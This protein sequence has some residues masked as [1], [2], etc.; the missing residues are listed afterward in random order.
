[1][2]NS[3]VKTFM[4][5]EY[6]EWVNTLVADGKTSGS[7][8]SENLIAYTQLNAKRMK[9]LNKT[10]NPSQEL[11]TAVSQLP[12]EMDWLIIT[13][14][15]CGDAAQN[16]PFIAK[17]A[18]VCPNVNLHL[19][20]RDENLDVMERYL[21]NG[22]RSIPKFIIKDRRDSKDLAIWGPRPAAAQKLVDA[23][24]A[25]EIDIP[26]EKF[27]EEIHSWY[28][29]DKNASLSYELTLLFEGLKQ[30]KP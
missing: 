7:N 23:N 12:I 10:S 30:T 19:I 2:E 11:I 24:K 13:E 27:A 15:W 4:Y 22:S 28:A 3:E 1:M 18:A 25:R 14:A 17:L 26:F 16:I 5:A 29:H 20:L 8:Q 9:R 6:I 21:T